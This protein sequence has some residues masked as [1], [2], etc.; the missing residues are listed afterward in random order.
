M[1]IKKYTLVVF[2]LVLVVSSCKKKDNRQYLMTI[3]YKNGSDSSS[4]STNTVTSQDIQAG[5]LTITGWNPKTSESLSFSVNQF[6]TTN[7]RQV[8]TIIPG[9]GISSAYY[10]SATYTNPTTDVTASS[11]QINITAITGDYVIGTFDF[12]GNGH[13]TGTFQAPRP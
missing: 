8:F 4:S 10:N 13:V 1:Q 7:N 12:Y 9:G 5:Y 6:T 11:G 2:L 3:Q